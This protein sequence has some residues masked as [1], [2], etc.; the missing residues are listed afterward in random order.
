MVTLSARIL[1]KSL[2]FKFHGIITIVSIYYI[3]HMIEQWSVPFKHLYIL[4]LWQMFVHLLDSPFSL[5]YINTMIVRCSSSIP[6][7]S[8]LVCISVRFVLG[9]FTLIF[10]FFLIVGFFL[11]VRL[12]QRAVAF[13]FSFFLH[14][15]PFQTGLW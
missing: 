9:L 15:V 13:F 7:V 11:I 5:I 1:K 14:C 12:S 10:L 2:F 4:L 8:N 3:C 6:H